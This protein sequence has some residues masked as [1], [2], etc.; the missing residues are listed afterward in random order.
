[1]IYVSYSNNH[2]AQHRQE[3]EKTASTSTSTPTRLIALNFPLSPPLQSLPQHTLH[4]LCS[5]RI[6]S[7]GDRHQTLRAQE[8]NVKRHEDIL[9]RFFVTAE[10]LEDDEV[11]DV[12]NLRIEDT[13]E[14]NLKIVLERLHEL[15]QVEIP[16]AERLQAALEKVKSYDPD[17]RK[18][19]MEA[20][21]RSDA[22]RYF[23]VA[24]EV[25]LVQMAEDVIAGSSAAEST[26][27]G[28]RAFLKGLADKG[29]ITTRPHITVVHESEVE[30]ERLEALSVTDSPA[31]KEDGPMKK[32]WDAC[33]LLANPPG[34]SFPTDVPL[35]E[36]TISH[37]VFSEKVMSL[38]ISSLRPSPQSLS[39]S[40][41]LASV[42]ES[43]VV[44]DIE[45]A[46]FTIGTPDESIRPFEGRLLVRE[47]R[48]EGMSGEGVLEVGHAISGQGRVVGLS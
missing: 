5:S 30:A 13:L 35:F 39:C 21:T 14:A 17:V 20:A 32:C 26:K 42:L 47:K 11:D 1:M 45:H 33:T 4:R 44:P 37:L 38:V 15:L 41:P 8:G 18:T 48:K 2:L 24:P 40:G 12:I 31:P 43:L 22:T 3:L 7:R 16:S 19:L 28:A 6:T 46:H 23:S 25:S 29:R 9:W 36:F 34:S 27:A 10:K